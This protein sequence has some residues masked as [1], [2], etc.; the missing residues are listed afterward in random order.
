M[1]GPAAFYLK[2]Q[3]DA[4]EGSNQYDE[5]QY[6]DILQRIGDDDGTNN[7]AGNQ[8]FKPWSNRAP[9]LSAVSPIGNPLCQ[10]AERSDKYKRRGE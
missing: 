6:S 5:S 7:I 9:K 4:E 2:M 3:G 10:L 8:K 1:P